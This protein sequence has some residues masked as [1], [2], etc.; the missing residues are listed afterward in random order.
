MTQ[1]ERGYSPRVDEARLAETAAWG[2]RLAAQADTAELRAAGRAIELLS[3]EVERLRAELVAGASTGDDDPRNAA[4]P[5]GRRRQGRGRGRRGR[6]SGPAFAVVAALKRRRLPRRP[7]VAFASIVLAAI[8]AATALAAARRAFAPSLNVAGP[9]QGAEFGASVQSKLVF[10]ADASPSALRRQRWTVDGNDVTEQVRA[11]GTRLVL[12]PGRLSEGEHRVRIQQS[13]GFLGA[14]TSRTFRFVVDRTPP[15]IELSRPLQTHPWSPLTVMGRIRD[16]AELTFNGETVSI[17]DGRFSR[18]LA[19]PVPKEVTLTARDRAGNVERLRARVTILPRRPRSPVR[20]VHVTF[21]AWA[22]PALRRG[23]MR[24]IDE[25]RIN[26][27]ELDLKDES[28]TVGFAAPVP[29]ARRIGAMRPIV[30]LR[31]AVE[32]LHSRGV[33]VIGRLVCFRDPILAAAAWRRGARAEVIQTPAGAPYAGY[34]GFTNFANPVVRQYNIDVALAAA[35]SGVDDVLYDYVRRPDGPRSSM[36]FPGL[37]GSP[38]SAIVSFLRET[39]LALRPYR[40]FLGAS[41]LGVAADRPLEVAQLVPAMA[42]QVDYIA[43]MIYPSHWGPGEYDVADPNA[44]PY[45]IVRRSLRAFQQDVRGTGARI[46]PWLQD[47]TLGV[48][49]GVREVR[50]QVEAAR[51]DRIDEFLLWDPAV[52]YTADALTR[53]APRAATGDLATP[54]RQPSV[55]ALRTRAPLAGSKTQAPGKGA[56]AVH[57][58]EL[59]M[60][61]VV[62]HHEIRPDRVGPYDQTPSEFRRELETLWSQGYWPVRAV[63]LATGNLDVPAGKTPVVLTF[64]DATQFQ[65]SYDRSGHIKRTTAIGV[66]LEFARTHPGFRPAGTFY[67]LRAP[68]AGTP[69][70]PAMLRWLARHGF[71]LGNHT[72]DHI[73]LGSL[74][75]TQ[76]Q[77]ELVLGQKVIEDAVPWARVRT[78]SLPLGVMPRPAAL[79]R[80]GRWGG[81]S[82]R[83]AGVFLVGANPAPSPFSRVF[84]RGAIPRIRSSHLPWNGERDFGAAY[85]L[86]ELRRHPEQ[87]YVSDG[88]PHTIAFPRAETA[89]LARRFHLRARPY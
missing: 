8:L 11:A 73:P 27:V 16:A 69:R 29:L 85:W 14:S 75:P 22:D 36:T 81:R 68:F 86:D 58:N 1:R 31:D 84:D 56:S 78:M 77:R 62:M 67:V 70:G 63:A 47:F 54:R 48:T 21:Y 71:E 65:F 52:T 38:E 76:V 2:R 80:H 41:V 24:L 87:R 42:R 28:G 17:S 7:I 46:V 20:A 23:V 55:P 57:A 19:V 44:Q 10:V 89:Q 26:A 15:R 35:S 33:R 30:D 82:Y 3:A 9:P 61:P 43:P 5:P 32:Q 6:H 25:H 53:D 51:A 39:R 88:D 12:V 83:N 72:H 66:L 45:A 40:T 60:V 59:G 37:K 50:A 13:G 18:R 49:Y 74:S 79:A 34:G 4:P 64:D